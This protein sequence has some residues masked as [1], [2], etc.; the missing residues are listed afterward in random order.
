[1]ELTLQVQVPAMLLTRASEAA[2]GMGLR[3]LRASFSGSC[4][5]R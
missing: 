3:G 2:D 4:S 1:M 5:E